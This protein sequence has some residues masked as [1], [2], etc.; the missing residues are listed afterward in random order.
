MTLDLPEVLPGCGVKT[1]LNVRAPPVNSRVKS[2][3]THDF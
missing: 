3:Y 2:L 1:H